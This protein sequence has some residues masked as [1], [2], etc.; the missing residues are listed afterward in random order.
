MAGMNAHLKV[1]EKDPFMLKRD[2]EVYI[3]F[4]HDL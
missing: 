4:S 3:G 2:E 1:Y